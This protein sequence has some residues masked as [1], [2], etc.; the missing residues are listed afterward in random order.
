METETSSAAAV[1]PRPRATMRDVAALAGVSLKTVSRVVNS[2]QG[3]S[4]SKLES[5]ERAIAQLDYRPNLGASS[6]RRLDGKTAA[7]AAVLDDLANPF[8][9][10][11]LRGMEN[12]ARARGVLLFAGSNDEDPAREVELVRAFTMRRADA[13]AIIPA[14]DDHSYLLNDVRAGT[15]VVFVD[16]PPRQLHADAVLADNGGGAAE[17]VVHLS[18]HG[19]R[20]IGF[21][22]G[23]SAITTTRERYRGF[24]EAAH[25]LGLETPDSYWQMD[26]LT[27][28]EVRLATIGILGQAAPPT[29]LFASQ[30]QV[31]VGV[32]AA[33]QG[34]GLQHKVALVGFDDFPLADRLDPP[35]TVVSQ[36]A[37]ALGRTAASL[38]F[39]RLDGEDWVPKYHRLPVTLVR[40]GSGEILGPHRGGAVR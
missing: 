1:S 36:D 2:E 3:V 39:R 40:R 30:N 15:P 28:E 16:R 7:I 32:I 33:L 9:A 6:L 38:L 11:V 19:H 12:E 18:R 37:V 29:A 35:V 27:A 22:G 26:L 20:R 23:R 34:L 8:A 14:G 25:T 31:T 10:A 4:S 24:R 21:L 17:A 5:V 13:L